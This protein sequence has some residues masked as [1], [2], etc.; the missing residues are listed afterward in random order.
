MAARAIESALDSIGDSGSR[1]LLQAHFL[2]IADPHA[3][4]S[5][6]IGNGYQHQEVQRVQQAA[7][8]ELV[9]LVNARWG[10]IRLTWFS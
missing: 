6:L 5:V 4:V 7:M 10:G 1:A 8:L 9:R 3:K 2:A